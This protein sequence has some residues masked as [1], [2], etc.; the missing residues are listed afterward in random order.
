MVVE[1]VEVVEVA[2]TLT[3]VVHAVSGYRLTGHES[4]SFGLV[5]FVAVTRHTRLGHKRG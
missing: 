4:T 2:A 3:G 5:I 1:V